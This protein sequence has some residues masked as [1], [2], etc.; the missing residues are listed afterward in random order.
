MSNSRSPR[1]VRSMTIGISGIGSPTLASALVPA[2]GGC[3]AAAYRT[4]AR[5][6]PVQQGGA[7][8]APLPGKPAR[9]KLPSLGQ[10][11]E[12]IALDLHELGSLLGGEHLCDI[13]LR[14][15]PLA[16]AEGA[17]ADHDGVG[18]ERLHGHAPSCIL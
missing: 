1:E 8:E 15:G 3:R 7:R 2:G 17:M 11:L 14:G 9:G 18:L 10:T 12:D 5:R 4:G 6:E 13:V 16:G